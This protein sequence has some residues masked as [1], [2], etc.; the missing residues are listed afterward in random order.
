M[1]ET[2]CDLLR[3]APSCGTAKCSCVQPVAATPPVPRCS[4]AVAAC[5]HGDCVFWQQHLM[6]ASF[7]YISVPGLTSLGVRKPATSITGTLLPQ[8]L[9]LHKWRPSPQCLS[10]YVSLPYG[11]CYCYCYCDLACLST[12]CGQGSQPVLLLTS[13]GV[14]KPATSMTG[15]LA[16]DGSSSGRLTPAGLALAGPGNERQDSVRHT[17]PM[18]R[19]IVVGTVD[20]VWN[21]SCCFWRRLMAS[22]CATVNW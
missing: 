16:S 8:R 12:N 4:A 5:T 11:Y 20:V 14:R 18:S 9:L 3:A 22:F 2:C 15:T 1:S 7:L 17:T 21:V 13:L 19:Y 6:L 10:L